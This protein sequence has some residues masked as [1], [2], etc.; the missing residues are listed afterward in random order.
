[1]DGRA[2][3]HPRRPIRAHPSRWWR[4]LTIY[5]DEDHAREPWWAWWI[6]VVG[7]WLALLC[8]LGGFLSDCYGGA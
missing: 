4:E 3:R 6:R 7:G 8:V 2:I 1:M 5:T